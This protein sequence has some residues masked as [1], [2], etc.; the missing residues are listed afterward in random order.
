MMEER[1][2][3]HRGFWS[4]FLHYFYLV[5]MLVGYRPLFIRFHWPVF[6]I[7]SVGFLSLLILVIYSNH[8]PYIIYD[9]ETLQIMLEYR[10]DRE[11][12]RFDELLGY[13]RQGTSRIFLYSLEFKPLRLRM[14]ARVMDQFVRLL[15]SRGIK[16]VEKKVAH[17]KG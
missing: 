16:A 4:Q 6:I 3:F 11:V 12:H 15:Q 17:G 10:E 8:I 9:E 1:G 5:P 2:Q 13:Y 7:Y 14:G